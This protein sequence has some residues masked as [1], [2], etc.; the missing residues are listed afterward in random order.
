VNNTTGANNTSF[1]SGALISNTTGSSNI[2]LGSNAGS[3]LTTGNNNID[4][5]ALGV[6]GESAKIRIGRQGT[7]NG[8]F[9][10]G[11]SGKT[12]PN[13]VGVFI[14]ANGQL[15]TIQSSAR[16]K[17]AIKPMDQASEGILDLQPVTF[18]YKVEIDPDAI[19][20]FGLIAEQV[21]KVNPDLVVRDEDGK[22][23]TVRYEAVNAM[24]LNEFLKDHRIV[25]EQQGTIGEVKSAAA[26][27]EATITRQ[28]A[29]IARQQ[30]QIEALATTVQKVSDQL[31]L[32]K[33]QPQMVAS[34][35]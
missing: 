18:R 14:N 26:R 16:Y 35:R 30:K 4:I 21:E 29:I 6:A 17:E 22:V 8:T 27:Q 15:G 19:P 24:L 5:G 33:L 28:E 9:I 12:V 13:G 7:Q 11:I 31:E 10:A 25:H 3:N 23:N 34:D 32:N 2:A 1:G 20:Q